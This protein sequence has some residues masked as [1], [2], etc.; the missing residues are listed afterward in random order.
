M[1]IDSIFSKAMSTCSFVCVAIREKRI[2]V[3]L[4]ATA[5]D[6]TG[7]TNIPSSKRS[8]VIRNVFSLSL[9]NRGIIGVDVCPI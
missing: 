1:N 9:I 6:T 2:N 7:F 8:F 5:G 4:G 3:S